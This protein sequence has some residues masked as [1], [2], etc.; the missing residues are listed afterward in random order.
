MAYNH[1]HGLQF[2]YEFDDRFL[3]HRTPEVE[4]AYDK[5]FDDIGHGFDLYRN[6]FDRTRAQGAYPTAFVDEVKKNNRPEGLLE[7][8]DLQWEVMENHFGNDLVDLRLAFEDFGHGVIY[9]RRRRVGDKVHKMDTGGGPPVG[10]HRWHPIIRA[11]V[12]VGVDST[13][14]LQIDRF[15]GLA[16]QIQSVAKPCEDD[17]NNLRLSKEILDP[18]REKWLGLDFAK[19]DEQFDS[20]PFPPDVP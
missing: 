15:V 7:I 2:W 1:A 11:A 9:D 3:F 20:Y 13:R 10:Y 8:S 12:L 19:I 5:L 17:R 4:A 16:W 6:L 14:W 18:I